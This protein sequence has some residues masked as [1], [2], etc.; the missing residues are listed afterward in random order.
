MATRMHN[1]CVNKTVNFKIEKLV[2]G[3]V[4]LAFP[5]QIN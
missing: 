3:F 4:S 1:G 2:Y 5:G